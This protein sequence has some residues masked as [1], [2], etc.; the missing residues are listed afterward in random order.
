LID[1]SNYRI[2]ILNS[3]H[4]R[5]AFSSGVESLDD[6]LRRQALQDARRNVA[7]PFVMVNEGDEVVGYYTLSAYGVRLS[8]L[9]AGVAKKLPRYPLLP[10]TLL[11][12]LAV[13][14]G[15]RGQNLGRLL[16]LDALF[17][18]LKNTSEV[19]SIGVIVEAIDEGARRFYEHHEFQLLADS[20]NRLFL[21]MR[22][23]AR[24]FE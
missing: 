12:R 13:S 15:H 17:R 18:S 7:A 10:A 11:G 21:G 5:D 20:P 3:E 24:L 22:T 19:A 9:P 16:L 6:Y 23:I 8:E 14:S 4:R 2:E 1:S